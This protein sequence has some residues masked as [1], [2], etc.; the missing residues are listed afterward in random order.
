[1]HNQRGF[2]QATARFSHATVGFT[3]IELLV[4]IAII[5][6]LST[7]AVV[8][9]NNARQ[10]ARD[11]RRMSD[12][13]ALQSAV[14]LHIAD[15]EHAPAVPAAGAGAWASLATG[16]QADGKLTAYLP[17]GMPTDPGS[18]KYVYCRKAPP[19]AS[20]YLV[21]AALETTNDIAGDLDGLTGYTLASQCLV[22]D[23]AVPIG[24]DCTDTTGRIVTSVGSITNKS[25]FCLGSLGN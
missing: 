2:T 20:K 5:G 17:A 23:N 15:Y 14:E 21:G 22:S 13:K 10:K 4:V 7:L 16:A 25:V 18:S 11:A 8:S 12:M 24:L 9:L 19:L 1:M 6:L 3:L